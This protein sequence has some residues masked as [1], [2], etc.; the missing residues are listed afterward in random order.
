MSKPLGPD[1]R[2]LETLFSVGT[3]CGFSDAEL[4]DRFVAR[5][6]D[7]AESAFEGLVLRHGPMVFDICRKILGNSHDAQDA[8]QATFLLLATKAKA[9]LRRGSVGSWLYGVALRVARRA[10]SDAAKRRAKE[11]HVAER[12][13]SHSDDFSPKDRHDFEALVEEVERLPQ[14]YREAVVLCYLEGMSLDAAAGQLACPI[15]TIGVRLMRAKTRLKSRLIRRGASVPA[16]LLIGGASANSASLALPA[17]L[18]DSTVKAAVGNAATGIISTAALRLI[19]EVSRSMLMIKLAKI[20]TVFV[21]AMVAIVSVG[22]LLVHSGMLG[23]SEVDTESPPQAP[24]SWVGKKAVT[25]YGSPV[26]TNGQVANPG[27]PFRVYTVE[28]LDGSRVR[29]VSEKISGWVQ[30]ADVVLLDEAIGFYSQE[31]RSNSSN[32]AAYRE[33]GLIWNSKLDADKAIADYSEAIRLDARFAHAFKDRGNAWYYKK[34]YEKALADYDQ[35]IRLDP[36]DSYAFDGRGKAWYGTLAYDKAIAD[37]TEAIRLDPTD[38]YVFDGRGRAWSG[39][40]QYDKAIVDFTEAIQLDHNYVWAFD[41]RGDAWAK[42]G[43]YDKAIADY[44]EAIRIDPRFLW[45]FQSRAGA[46]SNKKDYDKAIADYTEALRIDPKSVW[47]YDGRG[48]AWSKKGEYDKARADYTEAIRIDPQ[49]AWAY[50][51]RGLFWSNKGEYDKAVADYTEAIRIDPKIASVYQNRGIAWNFKGEYD[52]AIEDYSEAI[53]I[54][55]KI[56]SVYRSRGIAWFGKGDFD[57][58]IEDCSQAFRIDPFDAFSLGIRANAW[59]RKHE[60]GKA[61]ADYEMAIRRDLNDLEAFDALAWIRATC[62]EQKH[63]DGKKALESA[64][65]T[66]KSTNWNHAGYLETLAAACAEVGDFESAMK[67]QT[68]AIGL[69]SNP[70]EAALAKLR[71]ERY[72]RVAKPLRDPHNG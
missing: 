20:S 45:A 13:R 33:R 72:Y 50:Q 1:V 26:T 34:E 41:N 4:L 32:A 61:I 9:I 63:R 14:K 53:R 29:L 7:S 11:Q 40:H 25:K 39:K 24:A 64:T 51:S 66:C 22:G 68:K 38:P 10:R 8:F 44:T 47:A 59:V 21:G 17:A 2:L 49:F 43:Q 60:Y 18:I 58:S 56:A 16:G 62:P 31:I 35:A 36:T 54:N 23:A 70:Q 69:Y 67:W 42:Q 12:S 6:D 71:L 57:K 55:P 28:A 30:S 27:Q 52:K 3:S 48:D 65:S 46:W 19:S 37:Y 5:H 15:G